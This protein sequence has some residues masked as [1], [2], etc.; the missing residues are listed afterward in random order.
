MVPDSIPDSAV[1][2]FSIGQLFYGMYRLVFV[3]FVHV[4][5]CAIF[6]GVLSTLLVTVQERPLNCFSVPICCPE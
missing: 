3:S 5:S 6:E 4:L 1:I 2:F